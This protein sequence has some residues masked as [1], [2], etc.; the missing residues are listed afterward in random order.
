MFIHE[1]AFEN[2]C[3]MVANLFRDNKVRNNS[4]NLFGLSLIILYISLLIK[5]EGAFVLKHL[6]A[7]IWFAFIG[8]SQSYCAV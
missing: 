6:F 8:S 3:E 4:S 5:K 7:L 1:K 2:V